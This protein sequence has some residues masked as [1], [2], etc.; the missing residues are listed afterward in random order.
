M[1]R[2]I[3]GPA[4]GLCWIGGKTPP[5]IRAVYFPTAERWRVIISALEMPFDDERVT[6]YWRAKPGIYWPVMDQP[7]EQVLRN[8]TAWHAW[9]IATA[10]LTGIIRKEAGN[11]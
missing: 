5:L 7:N 8:P 9:A 1:I 6:V 11:G 2:I 4:D 10:A 3:G